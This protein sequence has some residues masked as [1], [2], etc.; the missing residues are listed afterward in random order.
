MSI[1]AHVWRQNTSAKLICNVKTLQLLQEST[2]A[3]CVLLASSVCGGVSGVLQATDRFLHIL[4]PYY[5]IPQL[6]CY[7]KFF[8]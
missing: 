6:L 5:F 7:R 2:V 4:W 1:A 8:L 3:Y